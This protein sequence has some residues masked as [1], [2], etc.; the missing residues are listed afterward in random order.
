MFKPGFGAGDVLAAA[1]VVTGLTILL[2]LM[3]INFVSAL[4]VLWHTSELDL[5]PNANRGPAIV[6]S[7][8]DAA[9]NA[10]NSLNY[11]R[12]AFLFLIAVGFALAC[13]PSVRSL[14]DRIGL[15]RAGS[16]KTGAKSR[17][18]PLRIY[19]KMLAVSA[20]L[21]TILHALMLLGIYFSDG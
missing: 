2:M 14:T 3:E 6:K 5:T 4:D 9:E 7:F 21:A 1:I 20:I 10:K 16:R 11:V 8:A 13:I 18:R 15:K 19:L 12:L 17:N